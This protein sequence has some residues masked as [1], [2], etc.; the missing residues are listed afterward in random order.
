MA[1]VSTA[2]AQNLLEQLRGATKENLFEVPVEAQIVTAGADDLNA[3]ETALVAQYEQAGGPPLITNGKPT[4]I[5]FVAWMA[6]ASGDPEKPY[7]NANRLAFVKEELYP[8]AAAIGGVN[9]LV[10]DWNHSAVRPTMDA[11]KVIGVWHS[12]TV[13]FNEAAQA[14]GILAQGVMFAWAHPE[15]ANEMLADQQRL[16][17]VRFSMACI[18]TNL[19]QKADEGGSFMIGHNPVFF[20]L[21]GLGVNNADVHANGIGEEGSDDPN[22]EHELT[23]KLTQSTASTAVSDDDEETISSIAARILL[24]MKRLAEQEDYTTEPRILAASN[25][26]NPTMTPEQIAALEA[27]VELLTSRIAELERLVSET[28]ARAVAAE[29]S[30]AEL[31]TARDA[32]AV[33]LEAANAEIVR[34]SEELETASSRLAE[35]D[36]AA[37]AASAEALVASRLAGLPEAFQKA[38]EKKSDESKARLKD[39]WKS[40][41]DDDFNFYVSEEL[42]VN[43]GEMKVGYVER[44]AKEGVLPSGEQGETSVSARIT[45]HIK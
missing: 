3:E 13:A 31:E 9:P 17:H 15:I 29:T 25:E 5:R 26:E 7:I 12:A 23:Q 33:T 19:E 4:V 34:L 27:S 8:A 11:Q 18:S 43:V 6:H 44:S 41:N 21:S 22:L 20:T 45:R 16:G 32:N 10:M 40:M 24:R 1:F 42:L 35:I 38:F 2:S 37:A 30:V 39:K 14:W 28:E 36:A